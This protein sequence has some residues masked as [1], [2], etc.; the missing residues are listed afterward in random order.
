[1][2]S[3]DLEH[4]KSIERIARPSRGALP[5]GLRITVLASTDGDNGREKTNRFT[6]LNPRK[7]SNCFFRCSRTSTQKRN[8]NQEKMRLL[9]N[10]QNHQKKIDQSS[11]GRCKK[12]QSQVTPSSPC[13]Y[14]LATQQPHNLV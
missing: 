4:Y 7:K 5:P 6:P 12:I 9:Q 2:K 14:C 8:Q 3:F 13:A 1:M 11:D 10:L